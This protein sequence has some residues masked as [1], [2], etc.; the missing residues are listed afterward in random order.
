MKPYLI[1]F[2]SFYTTVVGCHSSRRINLINK[3]NG[4]VEMEWV[5]DE[6]SLLQSKLYISNS[7]T[8]KFS[9]PNKK[10]HNKIKM[11]FGSGTW[12]PKEV[13]N[14]TDDLHSFYLKWD[15]SFIKLDSSQQI[16]KF[17]LARR[18]GM[19]NSQINIILK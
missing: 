5:I 10:P 15:T 11:S 6:D 8:V 13:K 19:D 17:L 3:T 12:T 9:L 4:D 18:R 1:L 7:D 16:M 14:F 2:F